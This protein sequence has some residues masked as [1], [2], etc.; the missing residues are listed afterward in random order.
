MSADNGYY[1]S[2]EALEAFLE[3]KHDPD[4]EE[5][6]APL[7]DATRRQVGPDE[8]GP[9]VASHM[10]LDNSANFELRNGDSR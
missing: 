5:R 10:S 2:S 1:V 7:W 9:S 3:R 6:L 4:W 8:D